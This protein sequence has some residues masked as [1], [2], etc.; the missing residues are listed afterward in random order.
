LYLGSF[1]T[2]YIIFKNAENFKNLLFSKK[3]IF[4]NENEECFGIFRNI[5]ILE[6]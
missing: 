2:N 4:V 1:S 6:M 3:K 5:L